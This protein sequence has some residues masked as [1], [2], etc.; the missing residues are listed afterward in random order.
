MMD[1]KKLHWFCA[2][3]SAWLSAAVEMRISI[4]RPANRTRGIQATAPRAAQ[5]REEREPR[6]GHKPKAL[7]KAA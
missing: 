4:R 7:R 1:K 6:T 3:H 5:A 2:W